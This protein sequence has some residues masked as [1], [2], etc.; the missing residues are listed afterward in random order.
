MFVG[1][2]VAV[3]VDVAVLVGVHVGDGVGVT[4]EQLPLLPHTAFRTGMPPDRHCPFVVTPQALRAG[5]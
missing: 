5:Y 3:N 1:V 4:T 2:I